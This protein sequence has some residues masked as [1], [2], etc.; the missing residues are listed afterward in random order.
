LT[1]RPR[2]H[3][4][5]VWTHAP[6]VVSRHEIPTVGNARCRGSVRISYRDGLL[7]GRVGWDA[8]CCPL[9]TVSVAIRVSDGADFV[10]DAIE[11]VPDQ[12]FDDLELIICD[13]ASTD[14]TPETCREYAGRD[15][16][17]RYL[18]ERSKSFRLERG[19]LAEP[20]AAQNAA[21][22][23]WSCNQQPDRVPWMNNLHSAT[24]SAMVGAQL[25]RGRARVDVIETFVPGAVV[26]A[27]QMKA[28]LFGLTPGSFPRFNACS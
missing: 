18:S 2:P 1:T 24:A 11:S 23:S 14:R 20:Q 8:F 7:I 15:R 12:A 28:R 5:L 6:I 10:A 9:P 16:C 13:N 27:E 19:Q 17:V 25:E 4:T 3:A 26:L 22:F 21:T